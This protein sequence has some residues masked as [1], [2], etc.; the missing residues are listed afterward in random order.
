VRA[1]SAGLNHHRTPITW[2]SLTVRLR[3]T[4]RGLVDSARDA[5]SGGQ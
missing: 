4:S 5:W 3:A 1:L 2:T